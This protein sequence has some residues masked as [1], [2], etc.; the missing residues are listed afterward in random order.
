MVLAEFVS[1]AEVIAVVEFVAFAAVVVIVVVA[2]AAAE[3]AMVSV[4]DTEQLTDIEQAPEMA[5]NKD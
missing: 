5:E 4:A 3:L 2:A 1:L